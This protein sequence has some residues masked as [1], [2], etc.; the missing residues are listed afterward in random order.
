MRSIS[1]NHID[2]MHL[3]QRRNQSPM[4]AVFPAVVPSHLL[5]G[6]ENGSQCLLGTIGNDNRGAMLLFKMPNQGLITCR[7]WVYHIASRNIDLPKLFLNL[8]DIDQVIP[9]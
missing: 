4:R 9:N 8:K 6:I 3:S 2:T 5:E 1:M 7:I